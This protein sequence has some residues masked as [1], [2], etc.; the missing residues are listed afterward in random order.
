MNKINLTLKTTIEAD[1]QND[2]TTF[3]YIGEY[4]I[5]NGKDYLL[6]S[7]ENP[8]VNTIIKADNHS[9]V[10]SRT[11]DMQSI[12]R[13]VPNEEHALSYKTPH[14]TFEMSVCGIKVENRL[15]DGSLLLKYELKTQFGTIGINTIE[16][17]IKEV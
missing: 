6:Y 2:V 16:I 14:G 4:D 12:M 13:I 7:E 15:N 1:G 8:R 5:K 10:I 11:G 3:N 17:T 9:A